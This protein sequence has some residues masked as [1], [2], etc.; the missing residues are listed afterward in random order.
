MLRLVGTPVSRRNV[1]LMNKNYQ[2]TRRASPWTRDKYRVRRLYFQRRHGHEPL[3]VLS[4]SALHM[5]V[6]KHLFS[7]LSSTPDRSL[8]A[9]FVK[10]ARLRPGT[11]IKE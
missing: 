8:E 7:F 2:L 9:K 10:P 5:I 6:L 1:R 3:H 4:T 11:S